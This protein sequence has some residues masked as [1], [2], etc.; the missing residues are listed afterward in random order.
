MD[1]RA[2]TVPA[3]KL[4][5]ALRRFELRRIRLPIGK[6]TISLVVPDAREWIRRGEWTPATEQGAEPPYWCQV[7][8]ASIAAARLLA[9][10]HELAGK[11]VLDL[12]CGLGVPGIVAARAGAR[13]TFADLQADA[14]AFAG[15]NASRH[16]TSDPPQVLQTDWSRDTL[17]DLFDVIVL[18][19]VSYRPVH[20]LALQ[21]H[22]EAC[23]DAHG[24]VVHADP[25][26]R[27]AT[28]FVRWLETQYPAAVLMRSTSFEHRTLD[29]R[30]C[31]ASRNADVVAR[32]VAASGTGASVAARGG[33]VDG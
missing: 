7:W 26:R 2:I 4:E 23:L 14:L 21:R 16:A 33:P 31:V 20:H 12:G 29:V 27:E 13:T 19:D 11:R 9:R 18:A 25:M 22:L 15:W 28:P 24:V 1:S 17:A 8:P 30:L 3:A 32:W 6:E 10:S 5:P